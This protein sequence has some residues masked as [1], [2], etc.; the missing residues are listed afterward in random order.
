MLGLALSLALA[1]CG[2]A[3]GPS[4]GTGTGAGSSPGADQFLAFSQCMRSHGVPNFPDPGGGGGIDLSGTNLNPFSPSFKAARA[5]CQ[6][7]LPGGGPGNRGPSAEAMKQVLAYSKCMRA[8]GITGFPDPT[9]KLPSSPQGY[10]GVMDRGGAVLAIPN[11]I[12]VRSP[13]YQRAQQACGGVGGVAPTRAA[14]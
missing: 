10:S 6:K 5:S 2:S 14:A 8:H 7:L 11:T 13:Q 4:A 12:D 1:A 3:S 9:T